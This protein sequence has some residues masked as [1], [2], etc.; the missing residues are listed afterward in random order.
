MVIGDG[1]GPLN[2]R[3]RRT[4]ALLPARGRAEVSRTRIKQLARLVLKKGLLKKALF[5]KGFEQQPRRG[6]VD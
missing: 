6:A 3:R 5:K 4:G 2:R 1:Y